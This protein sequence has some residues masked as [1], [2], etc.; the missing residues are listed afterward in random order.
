VIRWVKVAQAVIEKSDRKPLIDLNDNWEKNVASLAGSVTITFGGGMAPIIC[1]QE[2][3]KVISCRLSKVIT[4]IKG[5]DDG[6]SGTQ[7][8]YMRCCQK[9]MM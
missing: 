2:I 7:P 4:S 1:A 8:Q 5:H 9:D 3:W 6:K